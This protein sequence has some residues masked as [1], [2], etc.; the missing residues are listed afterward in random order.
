[1][2]E[3]AARDPEDGKRAFDFFQKRIESTPHF[4]HEFNIP[5]PLPIDK[6]PENVQKKAEEIA[7]R[8]RVLELTFVGY[9]D[10][11]FEASERIILAANMLTDAR[12]MGPHPLPTHTRS[13]TILKGPFKHKKAR[14][15]LGISKY[16]RRLKIDT[17]RDVAE[18]FLEF[19]KE[20]IHACVAIQVR[21]HDYI[22]VEE[23][24]TFSKALENSNEN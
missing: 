23:Y 22:P 14:D 7:N 12:V 17:T 16:Q 3:I 5:K 1:M 4:Q 18:R 11:F 2:K 21:V 13:W 10:R 15:Q 19:V 20:N 8:R 9:D 6:A 24:F